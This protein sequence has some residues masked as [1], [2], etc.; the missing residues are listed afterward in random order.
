[1]IEK[2]II[3][4][5]ASTPEVILDPA[6]EIF[7]ISGESFPEDTFKFYNP[8]FL[9]FDEYIKEPLPRTVLEFQMVY[10][11]TVSAKNF[12]HIMSLLEGV[13]SSG[14]I[15][16]IK[17]YYKENDVDMYESGEEFG[18][19]AKKIDFEYV[20]IIKEKNES[21]DRLDDMLNSIE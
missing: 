4:G 13:A 9:W 7:K 12:L 16:K 1:M 6:E 11:N 2:L 3:K 20:P 5:E 8:I 15:V 10:F 19:I 18:S 17:W 21:D 14:R